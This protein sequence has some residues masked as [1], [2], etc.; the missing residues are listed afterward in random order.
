MTK[1]TR[2]E[3]AIAE[4][5]KR[6]DVLPGGV[7]EAAK[8][9]GIGERKAYRL[10]ERGEYPFSVFACRVGSTYIVPRAAFERFLNG[11]WTSKRDENTNAAPDHGNGVAAR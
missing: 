8:R 3:L 2:Q 5:P 9:L 7:R 1:A 10:L 11:G 6:A 4:A